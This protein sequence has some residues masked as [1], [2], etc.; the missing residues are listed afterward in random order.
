MS[1]KNPLKKA[2]AAKQAETGDTCLSEASELSFDR[3]TGESQTAG[4]Q[5]TL[6]ANAMLRSELTDMKTDICN[7]LR[8]EIVALKECCSYR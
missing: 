6:D 2:G 8:G 5:E 7:S 3:P 1:R 4:N